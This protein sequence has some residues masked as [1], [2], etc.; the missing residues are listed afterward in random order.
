MIRILMLRDYIADCWIMK[1]IDG[2]MN[3]YELYK[4]ILSPRLMATPKFRLEEAER[5]QVADI[6][7]SKKIDYELYRYDQ[8]KDK[9]LFFP[10]FNNQPPAERDNSTCPYPMLKD[11][12]KFCDYIL[13]AEKD[14]KLYVLLI[15]LKS[16]N[17]YGAKKQLDASETFMEYVK[18]TANRISEVNGYSFD[19][20]SITTRQIILKPALKSKSPTN[21][22]KRIRKQ[23]SSTTSP[24]EVP[25]NQLNIELFCI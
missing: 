1:V 15:E 5:G 24:I 13:L 8:I 23:L 14:N 21:V 7:C 12:L 25:T 6:Y 10:F 11:L 4:R 19:S 17:S 22:V 2:A 16:G 9:A 18:S 20:A 3:E